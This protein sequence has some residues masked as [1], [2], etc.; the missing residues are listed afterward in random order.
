ME[1]FSQF[2]W[3]VLLSLKGVV[4]FWRSSDFKQSFLTKFP[5]RLEI[6]VLSFIVCIALMIFAV[7][8]LIKCVGNLDKKT[9]K[10]KKEYKEKTGNDNKGKWRQLD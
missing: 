3:L 8:M 10:S 7:V 5:L 2:A 6:T 9:A 4:L 1:A